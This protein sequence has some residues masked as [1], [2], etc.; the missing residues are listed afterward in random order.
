MANKRTITTLL[1]FITCLSILVG[2]VTQDFYK[3]PL[4]GGIIVLGLIWIFSLEFKEKF[5]TLITKPLALA[6]MGFYLLYV[7]S[8]LYSS[9]T[10]VALNDLQLKISLFLLPLFMLSTTLF[11]K[12][13]KRLLLN[14]FCILMVSMAVYDLYTSYTEFLISRN[15]S[16]FYYKNL[17]HLLISKPHYVAWYY[18]FAL[19]ITLYEIVIRNKHRALWSIAASILLVSLILLSSR[20]YLF[21]FSIVSIISGIV[22]MRKKTV[23]KSSVFKLVLPFGLLI[24]LVLIIPNTR[25]RVLDTYAE[26]NK[27]IDESD[28]R[29]TNPRVYIWK[30]STKL[31]KEKILLG[32]GTGD[33][34]TQLNKALEECDAQFWDGSKNV[35][36]NKKQLNYHNQFLQTWAE[37]GI[38]GFLLLLYL[39]IKPFFLKK[40]HPLFLI[41]VGLT[42]FG[43]LTESMLERQAGVVMLAFMYPLLYS[44]SEEKTED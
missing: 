34:K 30:Y 9:N 12:Y 2:L 41:F 32:Y 7:I 13:W 39:M 1:Y 43:F 5:K 17:P 21:A 16:S 42:I 6:L 33:A 8:T 3:I 19:F 38:L 25:A 14:T 4:T 24:S 23:S 31:I 37:V 29:Q 44:L 27:L 36:L 15:Y 40:K 10:S 22:W 35:L 26:I 28:H 11:S 20:A 18:S